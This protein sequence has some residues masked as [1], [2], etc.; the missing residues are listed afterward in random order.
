MNDLMTL[1]DIATMFR[2][3]EVKAK[4]ILG[5]PGFPAEAVVSTPRH[6]L[7]LRAEVRAFKPK[8]G[9]IK[10]SIKQAQA[11]AFLAKCDE[12]D[13]RSAANRRHH[14][15]KRRTAQMQRT[16][17]WADLG[18]IETVYRQAVA[19]ESET[20]I[21]H[22]VDHIIPLQGRRVSGLH[23]AA[24]LQVLPATINLSKGNRFEVGT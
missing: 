13:S 7:W 18:A 24:N 5:L 16:P 21:S 10:A 6:R 15:A 19:L 11:S 3:T 14:R 8:V 4:D 20:G 1:A 22:A 12:I 9:A 17:P 2:C 23:V